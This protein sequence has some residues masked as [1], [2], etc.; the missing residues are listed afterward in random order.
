MHRVFGL[1]LLLSAPATA[2]DL[3]GLATAGDYWQARDALLD[4][5][6]WT[7]EALADAARSTDR[8]TRLHATILLGWRQD[9]ARMDAVLRAQPLRDRADRARFAGDFLREPAS[10]PALLERLLHG[11]EPW[12]IRAGLLQVLAGTGPGWEAWIADLW[13]ALDAADLRV[14]AVGLMREGQPTVALPLLGDALRD[15]DAVV[16]AEAAATL[17][18]RKDGAELA[19]AL[20]DALGDGAPSVQAWAARALGYLRVASAADALAVRVG[21]A[22][23]EL[24]LQALR[25]LDR[26][27]P[28]AALALPAL[29]ALVADADARVARVAAGIR[30]R[31]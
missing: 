18:F 26:V 21:A 22:D 31:R 23:P 9:P 30:A 11:H 4:G 25:A 7:A 6:T 27:A 24:R 1:L 17:A 20:I 2:G 16:R 10:V 15:A 3:D 13:P 5:A 14:A 19:P 12:A 28:Q 8:A 29:D